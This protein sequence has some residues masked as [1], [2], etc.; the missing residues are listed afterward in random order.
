[1]LRVSPAFLPGSF[2]TWAATS[3][4]FGNGS[5]TFTLRVLAS[6]G[7]AVSDRGAARARAG[8][9]V[10][11]VL[12]GG[13]GTAGRWRLGLVCGPPRGFRPRPR[14]G[15]PGVPVRPAAAGGAGGGSA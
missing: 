7:A 5:P 1:M 13:K 3:G 2:S 11:G 8:R 14:P 4:T 6:G 15:G 9:R 12:L 10:R